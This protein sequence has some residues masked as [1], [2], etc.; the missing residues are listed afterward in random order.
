MR[1][2]TRGTGAAFSAV[3]AVMLVGCASGDPTAIVEMSPEASIAA[4]THTATPTPSVAATP[5]QEPVLVLGVDWVEYVDEYGMSERATI[6][7]VDATVRVVTAAL[8]APEVYPTCGEDSPTTERWATTYEWDDGGVTFE[9]SD[10][11]YLVLTDLTGERVGTYD[12]SL[13]VKATSIGGVRVQNELGLA[14]GDNLAMAPPG[15][16]ELTEHWSAVWG[17]LRRDDYGNNYGGVMWTETDGDIYQ[18]VTPGRIV[19]TGLCD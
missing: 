4:P 12:P 7:D 8:G 19:A 9:G 15:S 11:N 2:F 1:L 10:E 6:A 18:I 16:Y 3:L 14:V 17:G 13:G 5:I